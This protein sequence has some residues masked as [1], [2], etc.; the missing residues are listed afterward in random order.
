MNTERLQLLIAE[1]EA[2]HIEAIRRAF[3]KAVA[4]VEI[5][6]VG[7]LREFRAAVREQTP[8]L[9]L[10]DLNLP[11][12][13][14][15]EVLTHPPEDAL[16]PVLVMTAYGNQQIVVEV[17][18]AG[19]LDYVVKSPE[20]FAVLPRTVERVLREWKLLQKHQA[21]QAQI[22]AASEMWERTFDAVPDLIAIIDEKHTILR[23]NRAMAD[24]MGVTPYNAVGLTCY[25]H[26]HGTQCPPDFCPHAKLLNDGQEH[27]AEVHEDRLGGDFFVTCTPLRDPA[28]KLIGSVQVARDITDRKRAEAQLQRS[29]AE[30][31]EAQRVGQ[32]GSWEWDISTDTIVWSAHLYRLF[33]IEPGVPVPNYVRHLELYAPASSQ[34]LDAA[35]KNTMLTGAG[36]ELDLELARPDTATKW[37]H[38]RGEPRRDASGRIIGLRGTTQDITARKQAEEQLQDSN[39]QLEK[40]LTELRQM[41]GQVI[42]QENLRVLGQ[43]ASGIAHDFNN[44]LAPIIGFSELLM[45]HP[46]KLA[47]QEQVLKRLQIINTCATDAARVVRQM[48]EFGRQRADSDVFQAIDLNKLVR[49]TVEHTKQHWKDQAQASGKT[50][51]IVTDLLPVSPVSVEEF[52]IRELLTNLIFNA[53]D[54][55]PEG[56]TITLKTMLDGQSVRLSVSD[57]GT[58][59]SE[60]VQR[61]C[62]EPFFTTKGVGGTGLGLAMVQGIVQRHNG[63]VDIESKLGHGTTFI[64]RLPIQRAGKA[65][66]PPAQVS[67]VSQLL[68]VLVVDDDPLLCA[69]TEAF[70]MDD[71]HT[72]ETVN[73]GAAA[74]ERLKTDQFAVVI[75]D[76]A[77]PEMNGD[78]LAVA[79][80]Q[81]IPGLP[82]ILMTGFGDIMY[83]ANEIPPHISTILSKP[84]T[85][86]SLRAALTKVLPQF[87]GTA[88]N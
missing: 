78:Q 41:Q 16:F 28:G 40:A 64:I 7:T 69:I 27:S 86:A 59:M 2:A 72:V 3:Q 30:L 5:R 10:I 33:S 13:R 60:E 81:S 58:G 26:V 48:R 9:A 75:T 70:L 8:D 38:V 76:R 42:E 43:M 57:T 21:A 12:G 85:Q 19:A 49:Q 52:A 14:A 46:D 73:R 74:L 37:V 50:I 17:L 34:R 67:A 39:R 32:I 15:V 71:G 35:V 77:M 24:K 31:Q 82:V 61:R 55:L 54:A 23:V 44:A 36:Y 53:V 20:A 4:N 18:K 88:V 51:E 45:K 87:S 56:G 84:L 11:D 80:H 47:D 65:P 83:S 66:P 62:L 1:D 68:H 79:I 6:A 29:A 63:T 25:Q 22:A